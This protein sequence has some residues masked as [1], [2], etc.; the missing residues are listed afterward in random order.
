VTVDECF[1]HCIVIQKRCCMF[2][3]INNVSILL[4]PLV[5]LRPLPGEVHTH[6]WQLSRRCTGRYP[7]VLCAL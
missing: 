7:V 4:A 1:K 5:G 2:S 6:S 3:G